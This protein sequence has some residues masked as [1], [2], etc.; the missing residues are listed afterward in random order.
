MGLYDVRVFQWQAGVKAR[1]AAMPVPAVAGREYGE[2]YLGG[3]P[4]D[5][6]GLVGTPRVLVDGKPLE[7]LPGTG[8]LSARMDG[9]HAPL[10]GPGG[11]AVAADGAALARSLPASQVQLEMA[12]AGTQ[13]LGIVPVADSNSIVLESSW[14][15]PQFSGRFLPNRRSIG[16]GGFD[17]SWNISSLASAAQSQVLDASS[18]RLTARSGGA[19]DEPAVD[20]VMVALVDPVDVY[21][22]ADRASKYGI[23]FV[24]LTFVGFALFELVKQLRIHPLQYLLVGLALAI[25]FLLLLGLSEH[26]A[27]WKAFVAAATACIGLQFVYLSGVLKS[28]WRAG[29][30]ATMLTALYGALYSLLVSED[31]ALLMG[32]L[33]LFGILAVVMLVTRRIDWYE[34]AATLG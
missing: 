29:A 1:F 2:P 33:L 17:A 16:E 18:G 27:F 7:L 14:P 19:G 10:A 21:T 5:V 8:S 31:N 20:S 6:R 9:V 13:S 3:G 34:R 4:Y 28:W 30:F 15:H 24:L 23:L 32:S 11:S 25:F 22:Q 12:I 26:M